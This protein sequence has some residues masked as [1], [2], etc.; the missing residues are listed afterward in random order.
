VKWLFQGHKSLMMNLPTASPEHLRN[1][2]VV[3]L[4]L[5]S[6]H[7]VNTIPRYQNH[8]KSFDTSREW[9]CTTYTS[10]CFL[11]TLYRC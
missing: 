2:G 4:P 8:G 1:P 3:A 9:N 10:A 11:H 6:N 5:W 7:W